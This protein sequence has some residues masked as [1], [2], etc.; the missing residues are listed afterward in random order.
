M[1]STTASV[2]VTDIHALDAAETITR[3]VIQ[4]VDE[5]CSRFREDSELS[6]LRSDF[7]TG[8]RVSPMLSDLV[9]KALLAAA[10]T[11][12]SV[13]PTL[14]NELVALGYD[15]D[16]KQVAVSSD[17]VGA[18]VPLTVSR[19]GVAGWTRIAL[20]GDMLTVP[21]DIRI[22][23]GATAKAATADL[24]AGRI[25]QETGGGVLVSLGGDIATAGAA[26]PWEVLV[27]D[28]DAD[29]A[30]QVALHA[31]SCL[32][33]SST[34]KRRWEFDGHPMHHILDPLF[35]LPVDPVWRSVSVAADS[36]LRA[37]ALS[38][39]AIVRGMAA[40]DWLRSIGANA[41]LIDR[42]GRVV[43][44]G[45]WPEPAPEPEGKSGMN[46]VLA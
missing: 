27:Q 15:R 41:R 8:A 28:T 34:Q 4:A 6:R 18:R 7:A 45:S 12:G 3:E 39:A 40:V 46:E 32:A 13:D 23:L 2:L 11:G 20:D 1:W 5:A 26:S 33:T 38:T 29:P 37:N 42:T 21:A 24:A 25:V 30:Q 36:C 31:G 44:T 16:F 19:R 17:A 35:G 43:L 10:W 22:D 9:S 14:G